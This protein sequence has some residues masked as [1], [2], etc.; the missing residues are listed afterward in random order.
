MADFHMPKGDGLFISGTFLMA[1][2]TLA[3]FFVLVAWA[4][5]GSDFKDSIYGNTDIVVLG[6]GIIAGAVLIHFAKKRGHK[7]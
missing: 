6:T 3:L 4:V 5:G 2:C 7:S 1:L